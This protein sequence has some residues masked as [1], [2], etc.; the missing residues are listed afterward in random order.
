M[1]TSANTEFEIYRSTDE[2]LLNKTLM[3]V[4]FVQI[5]GSFKSLEL[6][7]KFLIKVKKSSEL[8]I[9]SLVRRIESWKPY[10]GLQKWNYM[11]YNG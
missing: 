6:G 1:Q 8:E 9:Q 7:C 2:K 4:F 3:F 5:E 10:C 11:C